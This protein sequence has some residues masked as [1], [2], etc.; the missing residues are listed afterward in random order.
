MFGFV[1]KIR[2]WFIRLPD[3]KRYFELITAFLS[4]PVLLS[5]IF[6][7]YFSIQ[8]RRNE[9]DKNPSPTPAVITIIERQNIPSTDEPTSKLTVTNNQTQCEAEIGPIEITSP[10]ENETLSD[11]PLCVTI[12]RDNPNNKYCAVVWSQR[13]NNSSWSD[14][15]DREICIYNMD[16]G[17]KTLELRV[18]SIVTGAEKTLKRVFNYE[19][20]TQIATPTITNTPTPTATI[21]PTIF[22]EN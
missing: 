11:N 9:E 4:I 6:V 17:K 5:V 12:V 20:L 7:N 14:F 2:N 18:K 1:T 16:S 15:T 22:E 13:I 3:K 8:E 10:N 21:I 19:N